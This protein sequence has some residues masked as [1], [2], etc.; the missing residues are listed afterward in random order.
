MKIWRQDGAGGTILRCTTTTEREGM[1]G[2]TYTY[3]WR[4]EKRHYIH[5]LR[6]AIC[7]YFEIT[8]GIDLQMKNRFTAGTDLTGREANDVYKST[9]RKLMVP[10]IQNGTENSYVG[11][12]HMALA[13]Q[14]K[15][16]QSI[17]RNVERR[18]H[19]WTFLFLVFKSRTKKT[20][21]SYERLLQ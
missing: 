21:T 17:S 20:A 7:R 19:L 15:I 16:S 5:C 14:S 4:T 11:E 1:N 9:T 3:S 12:R 10:Q 8:A 13:C 2:G 6:A 18:L